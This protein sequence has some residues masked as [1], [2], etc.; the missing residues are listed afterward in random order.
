MRQRERRS[1]HPFKFNT[2]LRSFLH[3]FPCDS[4]LI[5]WKGIHS[6]FNTL[7]GGYF[8]SHK[9]ISIQTNGPIPCPLRQQDSSSRALLGGGFYAISTSI[10]CWIL[11]SIC[12]IPLFG[13]SLYL[14]ACWIFV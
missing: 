9:D 1:Q 7:F 10:A 5:F 14:F 8:G 2:I 6:I 11:D 4:L 3:H 13:G 12:C